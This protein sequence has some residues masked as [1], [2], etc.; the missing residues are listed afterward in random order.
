[1]YAFESRRTHDFQI[2]FAQDF[3]G[4]VFNDLGDGT[5]GTCFI[6]TDS[7]EA[8]A[9]VEVETEAEAS[10]GPG[11]AVAAGGTSIACGA[12][13]YQSFLTTN[14]QSKPVKSQ[15]L[16]AVDAQ[17]STSTSVG[18]TGDGT[19]PVQGPVVDGI[20][21]PLRGRDPTEDQLD[22]SEIGFTPYL[23]I[24]SE[25]EVEVESEAEVRSNCKR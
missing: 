10:V 12:A 23:K 25:T 20:N 17:T 3:D 9:E 6:S 11:S 7:S 19:A 8:E 21:V 2:S 15:T 4:R 5:G 16:T 1:M 18:G 14:G 24:D 13:G 22:Q